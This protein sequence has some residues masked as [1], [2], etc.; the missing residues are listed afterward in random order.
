MQVLS[1]YKIEVKGRLEEGIVNAA[2]PIQVVVEE[3]SDSYTL[4]TILADQSG[5]V[6][7]IRF[8][9]RQGFII[10]SIKRKTND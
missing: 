3:I 8:L 10:L 9:H 2:S 1:V 6:G 5:L 7:M 4:F